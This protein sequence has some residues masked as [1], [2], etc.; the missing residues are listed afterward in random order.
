MYVRDLCSTLNLSYSGDGKAIV[1][2]IKGYKKSSINDIAICFSSNAIKESNSVVVLSTPRLLKTDKTL[3]F[4][5]DSILSTAILIAKV[6]IKNNELPCYSDIGHHSIT[7]GYWSHGVNFSIGENTHIGNFT[8]I[9]DDVTIGNNCCIGTNV[10]IGSGTVI[11]DN[12]IINNGARI[13]SPPFFKHTE[14]MT[15]CKFEHFPGVGKVIIGSN[16]SIG[17]NTV[18]QRGVFSDTIIGKNTQI[19]DSV[20]VGHDVEI[21]EDCWIVTQTGIG[22]ETIIGNNV[23]I[24]GQCG[25][26]DG[27]QIGDN[28]VIMGKSRVTKNVKNNQRIS[29]FHGR[30]HKEELYVQAV[31]SNFRRKNI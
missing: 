8:S 31:L 15:K 12:V 22:G 19:G 17:T 24:L 26:V 7:S 21:G 10:T 4:A 23:T 16:A 13:A 20:V 29:G 27:I 30:T 3:I 9:D 25:I 6:L 11:S 28:V 14:D 1:N 2:G 5:V 18:V